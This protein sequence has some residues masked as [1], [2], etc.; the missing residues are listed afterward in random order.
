MYARLRRIGF[1]KW[2]RSRTFGIGNRVDVGIL[3]GADWN[4]VSFDEEV[5]TN[6][7]FDEIQFVDVG[8]SFSWQCRALRTLYPQLP[9]RVIL[10]DCPNV[11]AQADGA[12]DTISF[13]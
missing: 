4:I 6:A 11:T 9:Y 12:E 13:S 5:A 1:A 2:R 7:E 10:Q 3:Y 8:G